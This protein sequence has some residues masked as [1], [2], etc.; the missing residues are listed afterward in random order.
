MAESHRDEIAKLEALCQS[1]PGGRSF[2]HLA[3]AYR[4]AGELEV[5]L[6]VV[7]RGLRRH[8]DYASAHV[9]LGRIFLDLKR[10][11][12][13]ADAFARVLQLD[14]ENL[15]ALRAQGDL[16]RDA[17]RAAD[18]LH[19]YRQLRALDP[20]DEALEEQ[21]ARLEAE[22]T[23][24]SEPPAQPE[25]SLTPPSF[26]SEE[27]GPQPYPT[28]SE[29]E[30]APPSSPWGYDPQPFAT[31]L[32]GQTFGAIEPLDHLMG[33]LGDLNAGAMSDD[34]PPFDLSSMDLGGGR[35]AGF[36]EPEPLGLVHG[37]PFLESPVEPAPEPAGDDA[38]AEAP[39]QEAEAAV[40]GDDAAELFGA[41]ADW[42]VGEV[43]D[44]GE[45]LTET[46]AELYRRQGLLGRAA[47]VYRALL[48]DRPGD[49]RLEARLA[50]VEAELAGGPPASAGPQAVDAA[51]A[52]AEGAPA[53]PDYVV[54]LAADFE[55]ETEPE[56]FAAVEPDAFAEA[57]DA[58]E[59]SV[60][61]VDFAAEY[62][63][64]MPDAAETAAPETV[65]EFA[66]AA[67]SA[68]EYSEPAA[69]LT[70]QYAEFADDADTEEPAAAEPLAVEEIEA[71]WTG[72]NGAV[73]DE[74]TPYVWQ[75]EGEGEEEAGPSIGEYFGALL[76]WRSA[77]L[78]AEESGAALAAASVEPVE[79]A[80][81]TE[82]PADAAALEP[83]AEEPLAPEAV[84]GES[85]A[86]EEAS[87]EPFVADATFSDATV[88]EDRTADGAGVE[89]PAEAD[90]AAPAANEL[91]WLFGP[92]G[93]AAEEPPASAAAE[94][95]RPA[96]PAAASEPSAPQPAA[97]TE[98]TGAAEDDDLEMF[99]AWLQS[100]KR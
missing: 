27:P 18:A 64:A 21:V 94:M 8:S 6:D 99:R 48:G 36:P 89:E 51:E 72:G 86:A 17:G 65:A 11:H 79:A 78:P 46:M 91:D 33:D 81:P 43:T 68:V 19:Y 92:E 56:P 5:A 49:E 29:P 9:V 59:P 7:E 52:P 35:G 73:A 15:V 16:A 95:E 14:P 20:S 71:A 31:S 96:E 61:Y 28:H 90:G 30:P 98:E 70:V 76:S 50:E 67:G 24:V 66:E 26:A 4:K 44:A 41:G 1:N 80:E 69:E 12:E 63:E 47:E 77:V 88:I 38:T 87:A 83:T 22:A 45:V 39:F 57:E 74:R 13:A 37:I 60:E 58:A 93:V 42:E 34:T 55:P 97:A 53:A 75:D 100:L 25:I 23:A 32:P 62:G 40:P 85:A 3:E 10:P 84:A 54:E 2:T 82:V